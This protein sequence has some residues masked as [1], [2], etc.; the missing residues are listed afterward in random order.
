MLC[1][2]F[3]PVVKKKGNKKRPV[4]SKQEDGGLSLFNNTHSLF[5]P[6]FPPASK[7]NWQVQYYSADGPGVAHIQLYMPGTLVF[8]ALCHMPANQAVARFERTSPT[9][10]AH[11]EEPVYWQCTI[12]PSPEIDSALKPGQ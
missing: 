7:N 5:L 1:Y 10:V 6:S 4:K 11:G 2:L 8:P 9:V 3:K 12:N